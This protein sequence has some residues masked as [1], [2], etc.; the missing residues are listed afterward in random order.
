MMSFPSMSFGDRLCF[1]RKD[2]RGG[3][4][5][6]HPKVAS[7]MAMSGL[8]YRSDLVSTGRAIS[9]LFTLMEFGTVSPCRDSISS[10]QG[11]FFSY[12]RLAFLK[13]LI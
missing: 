1:S 13:R 11:P 10:V 9:V 12:S 7:S 3:G 4:G 5:W 2:G 8:G 6:V